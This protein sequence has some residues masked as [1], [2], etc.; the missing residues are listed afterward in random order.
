MLGNLKPSATVAVRKLNA[1][2]KFYE[3]KLGL[4]PDASAEE[5]GVITYQNEGVLL[6]VYESQYAGTNQATSVT[7]TVDRDIEGVVERLKGRGV[8]FEHYDFPGTERQGDLHV[9][10]NIKNAW[11]KD[12]DGNIHSLV[13]G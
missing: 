6:F 3:G 10:G 12:P 1:A 7:W 2:R 13:S 8:S 9:T 5:M 11:F 4:Q